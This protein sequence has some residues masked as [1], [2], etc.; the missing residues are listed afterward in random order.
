MR[1]ALLLTIILVPYVFLGM[2]KLRCRIDAYPCGWMSFQPGPTWHIIPVLAAVVG[3]GWLLYALGLELTVLPLAGGWLALAW[4][5]MPI[6]IIHP[7]SHGGHCPNV[8]ILCH[9]MPVMGMGGLFYWL[10]PFVA[11]T[12]VRLVRRIALRFI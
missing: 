12:G 3:V 8:P 4:Y 5:V 11:W 2:I 6:S 7:P 9:D 1:R 10:L